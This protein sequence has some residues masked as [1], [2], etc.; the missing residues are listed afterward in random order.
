MIFETRILMGMPITVKIV[1]EAPASI[2]AD[3]FAHFAE[4]DA[5]FSPFKPES[6]ISLFNQG[7]LPISE[8]SAGMQEVFAI[9]ARTKAETHGYFDIRRPDGHVDPSGIVKGWAIR[10]AARLVAAA[11]IR[12][13]F[14]E[15][16]GDIQA[17]GKNAA[18]E[19]W[20]FGIRNPFNAQ[21]II[22]AVAPRG[23]GIATSGSYVRG[24]HVYN[25]HRPSRAIEEIVSL[26]V[27]GPDVLEADRFATAA[28]AM[29]ETG[30]HFIEAQASLEGY[31]V[32]GTGVATQTSG[33][34]AFVTS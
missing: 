19:D 26:T 28:F 20:A 9:A 4:V 7:R 32:A 24:Q 29:G 27:I 6:E 30:I 8:L 5:R 17:V 23:R 25:P 13:F 1:D 21:Q 18:G 2:F 22:K 10:D 33:F 3:V 31:V 11:G 12:N 34:R 14:V 16:G 15:A